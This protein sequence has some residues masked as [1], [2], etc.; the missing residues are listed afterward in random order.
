MC[1][2]PASKQ[3]ATRRQQT[4]YPSFHFLSAL[5][6]QPTLEYHLTTDTKLT[7]HLKTCFTD[8]PPR[9]KCASSL[10]PRG[11]QDTQPVVHGEGV[12][13]GHQDGSTRTV[14]LRTPT[15]VSHSLLNICF[16][17]FNY[18]SQPDL[19]PASSPP[20]PPLNPPQL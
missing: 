7:I 16:I 15:H 14:C 18:H 12:L 4:S 2:F 11:Y 19:V 13:G 10:C 5:N 20:H 9:V 1:C 17:F 8:L 6:H 3:R